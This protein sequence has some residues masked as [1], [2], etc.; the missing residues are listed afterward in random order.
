MGGREVSSSAAAHDWA[1]WKVLVMQ[2][3]AMGDLV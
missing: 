2:C 3:A 1:R